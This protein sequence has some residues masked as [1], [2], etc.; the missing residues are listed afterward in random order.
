MLG[1][2]GQQIKPMMPREKLFQY[3]PR[4]LS[5][6]ELVAIFLGV[7]TRKMSVL[8]LAGELLKHFNGL[9]GLMQASRID[10]ERVH[11]VGAARYAQLATALEMST[12]YL[13]HGME[14]GETISD[15]GVT[16]RFLLSKLRPYTRE[17]FACLFLDNQHRLIAYEEMF[18]GT[19][20]GASV[21]PREVLRR[22]LELNA[23]A[24]VFAHNHPSGV[25]EP[26][27]ADK[28]ITERLSSALTLVD[29]RVLDHMVVGD[30]EVV[31]FAERGL[32]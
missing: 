2:T 9:R 29:I 3:G 13:Q 6:E 25:A 31:S 16:R 32:L 22:A 30:T 5:D 4:A 14:R 15:P 18:F 23:A 19:I 8:E 7:G 1:Q 21:H 28:R 17:V 12:R 27:Q 11:G 20:D 26:S 24:V 10:L